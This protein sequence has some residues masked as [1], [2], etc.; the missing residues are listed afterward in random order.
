M[1]AVAS[2]VAMVAPHVRAAAPPPAPTLPAGMPDGVPPAALKPEPA[3]PVPA[4]WP[5]PDAF[6]RTSGSVRLAGG[7]LEWSDFLYDDHGAKG[8][9]VDFPVA[10]LAASAGTYTYATDDAKMNGADIFR[11]SVGLT[12]DASWWR[13]DWNTLANPN[14]PIAEFALDTDDSAATGGSA[15]PAG[16][17]VAS[18]GIDTAL[19]LSSKGAWLIDVATGARRALGAVRVDSTARSFVLRVPRSTMPVAGTWRIRLAS[20]VADA[21]G[22]GFAPVTRDNGALPGQP[23]VYNI[24]FRG[25]YQE[26]E[27]SNYWM[28]DAQATALA[29]GDVS[30]FS[31]EVRWGELAAKRTTPEPQPT[32]YTNRWYVSSIELGQGAV[33]D[34]GNSTE[35]LRPNFL[36]RV[37]PYAI[38]VPTT[39]AR[40]PKAPLTWILHSLS[41]QHNQ[42]GSFNPTFVTQAC[43]QRH[44][45]CV[46]PLGRG[47]DGWYFDE[48]ELDFWEVWNRVAHAYRLDSERTALSGYSMG[49]W[50][51]YK[52]GLAH[53]DLFSK[54]V[55]L[56]G[57]VICGLRAAPGLPGSAGPGRCSTDGDSVPIIESARNLPYLI[58]Q[59]AAD[60]LV[61]V[62]GVL[63]NVQRFDLLGY[64]YRFELYPAAD[65]LAYPVLDAFSDQA[66]H[67]SDAPRTR[68]PAQVTYQWYPN[69]DRPDLG[70]GST[71][72][73]WVRDTHG[74]DVPAG[75][76]A[77]ID[78]V[79]EALS[80]PAITPVHSYNALVPGDPFPAVVQEQTWT[81]GAA[82][83]RRPAIAMS[84]TNVGS[85]GVDLVRAGFPTGSH[86]SIGVNTD[87]RATLQLI[88]VRAGFVVRLDGAVIGRVPA[89]GRVSV[90]FLAGRHVIAF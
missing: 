12:P 57:P 64:R 21:T 84:L 50:G 8:E 26:P 17:G 22:E 53:P 83:A 69:L 10:G 28:D 79:S 63:P 52:L 51:T 89:S 15:W 5:F 48:A 86:G 70:I 33:H 18:P 24:A 87:G 9:P 41:E 56:E 16:A 2:T 44:S 37:Q 75:S 78:A 90:I 67:L 40:Q 25:Y 42:Y 66:A 6:P 34:A 65:H 85:L 77:R 68:S 46:T 39:Y 72:A 23:A 81:L 60:E 54:A 76:L 14:V 19:L 1:L 43:E 38:Y 58:S 32:G 88:G 4:G 80:R 31:S 11:T 3:L 45:I 13:V 27:K 7:A 30:P 36:G 47:P 35:D 74:R 55:V 20:G 29:A 62:A 59:G 49:G 73:Y 82:P 71:G 61:P